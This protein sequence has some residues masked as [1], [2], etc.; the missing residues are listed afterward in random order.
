MRAE[1]RSNRRC[2]QHSTLSRLSRPYAAI[3]CTFAVILTDAMSYFALIV[4]E[5]LPVLYP[6]DPLALLLFRFK[7]TT[8]FERINGQEA[9]FVNSLRM[10]YSKLSEKVSRGNRG[11]R[12]ERIATVIIIPI[13]RRIYGAI[14]KQSRTSLNGVTLGYHSMK[15]SMKRYMEIALLGFGPRGT[16][17]TQRGSVAHPLYNYSFC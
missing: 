13:E 15:E 17:R 9:Y 16:R 5:K 12:S 11:K 4:S 10:K 3:R 14:R 1:A 2:R 8:L 7:D 6:N